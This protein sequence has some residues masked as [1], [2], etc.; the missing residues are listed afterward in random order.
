MIRAFSLYNHQ[1]TFLCRKECEEDQPQTYLNFSSSSN[2]K[3]KIRTQQI[4]Q[5]NTRN[6]AIYI[7]KNQYYKGVKRAAPNCSPGATR[8]KSFRD[9]FTGLRKKC[10][11]IKLIFDDFFGLI[12]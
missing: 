6:N 12:L 4:L 7:S 8:G 10:F 11:K 3:L 2:P 5:I 1:S 9:R